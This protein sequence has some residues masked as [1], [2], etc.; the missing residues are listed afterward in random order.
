MHITPPTRFVGVCRR[1]L[2]LVAEV[3]ILDVKALK[4]RQVLLLP[5]VAN[6]GNGGVVAN[7]E[8]KLQR[9]VDDVIMTYLLAIRRLRLLLARPPAGHLR[10]HTT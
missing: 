9:K 2:Q 10:S 7:L 5:I 1:V 6:G 4:P 3:D 8:N